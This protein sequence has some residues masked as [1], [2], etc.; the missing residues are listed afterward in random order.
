[1]D[2]TSHLIIITGNVIGQPPASVYSGS[3]ATR[4]YT[5]TLA[6]SRT[7]DGTSYP[8]RFR[9]TAWGKFADIARDRVFPG[10]LVQVTGRLMPDNLSGRP[11]IRTTRDGDPI[12]FYEV[13]AESLLFL[14]GRDPAIAAE[15]DAEESEFNYQERE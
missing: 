11:R 1:M 6:T 4:R 5:F 13:S 8:T 7:V 9:V 3:G 10:A 14:T 15:E 12:A 2:K